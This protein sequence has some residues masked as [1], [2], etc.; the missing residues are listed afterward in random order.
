[1]PFKNRS[2]FPSFPNDSGI[3]LSHKQKFLIIFLYRIKFS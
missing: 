3:D 1:L 2:I